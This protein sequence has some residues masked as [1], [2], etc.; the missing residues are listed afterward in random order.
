MTDTRT[1]DPVGHPV[2]SLGSPVRGFGPDFPGWGHPDAVSY[3]REIPAGLAGVITQVE[4]H[5][6]NPWTRYS[7]RY[8]GLTTHGA[9]PGVDFDWTLTP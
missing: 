8:P 3:L 1:P 6:S 7:I 4:S 2:V 9:V 5:G